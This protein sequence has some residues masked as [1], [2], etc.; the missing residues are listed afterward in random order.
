MQ[1]RELTSA[2]SY[3]TYKWPP[4]PEEWLQVI[5][6][7][8]LVLVPLEFKEAITLQLLRRRII[9]EPSES[10]FALSK[11]AL[12]RDGFLWASVLRDAGVERFLMLSWG[13]KM[14]LEVFTDLILPEAQPSVYNQVDIG[15]NDCS[16]G[17]TIPLWYIEGQGTSRPQT[18]EL[19]NVAK[20]AGMEFS[21]YPYFGLCGGGG[22]GLSILSPL[23]LTAVNGI[24][25]FI[26]YP[27]LVHTLK[28]YA[29]GQQWKRWPEDLA[30]RTSI[31][32]MLQHIHKHIKKEPNYLG[33]SRI[34]MSIFLPG[35]PRLWTSDAFSK[36][37]M[38]QP[39]Q[40]LF[41]ET[42]PVCKAT[43]SVEDYLAQIHLQLLRAREARIWTRQPSLRTTLRT[44]EVMN[45]FGF[46]HARYARSL[47]LA[48][49]WQPSVQDSRIREDLRERNY[50]SDPA[51]DPGLYEDVDPW[52]EKPRRARPNNVVPP[53]DNVPP[54][55]NVAP[56]DLDMVPQEEP[57]PAPPGRSEGEEGSSGMNPDIDIENVS[58][59]RKQ[60]SWRQRL[61]HLDA[62]APRNLTA[63]EKRA[64]VL[65]VLRETTCTH[66]VVRGTD[67][68]Q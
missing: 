35:D 16:E 24:C 8:V 15:V 4:N 12:T 20:I 36:Y 11:K 18:A 48:S 23:R 38:S 53:G 51:I 9:F 54:D 13:Q 3:Q 67:K 58:K 7:P 57:R 60:I 47:C 63:E 52:S 64:L 62:G 56:P 14:P 5:T 59:K 26:Q 10:P 21:H 42:D 2:T 6:Q 1:Y 39:H 61:K 33:G 27:L 68:Y 31:K 46:C 29:K 30:S 28:A 17:N 41:Q 66:C 50:C 44:C 37:I 45:Q 22:G 65:H 49:T 43:L 25:R 32:S 55:I 19:S 34:E 40:M